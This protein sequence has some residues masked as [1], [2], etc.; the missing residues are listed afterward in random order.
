MAGRGMGAA[1]RGGGAVDLAVMER[2]RHLLWRC[3]RHRDGDRRALSGRNRGRARYAPAGF[4]GQPV[5]AAGVTTTIVRTPSVSVI[6]TVSPPTPAI[7]C[8]TS[9]RAIGSV[10]SRVKHA[11]GAAPRIAF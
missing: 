2:Q 5:G 9:M 6:E 8:G 1:T 7:R 3:V 11:P 10:A 4:G